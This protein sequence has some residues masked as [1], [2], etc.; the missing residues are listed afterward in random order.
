MQMQRRSAKS[1]V[2]TLARTAANA[3]SPPFLTGP[4]QAQRKSSTRGERQKGPLSRHQARTAPEEIFGS[5]CSTRLRPHK[6]LVEGCTTKCKGLAPPGLAYPAVGAISYRTHGG[7]DASYFWAVLPLAAPQTKW[8]RTPG[9]LPFSPCPRRGFSNGKMK[10]VRR[11]AI[12][13][14]L[15]CIYLEP[16]AST[17]HLNTSGVPHPFPEPKR[18]RKSETLGHTYKNKGYPIR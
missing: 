6:G 1:A 13:K 7:E 15:I 12:A 11:S 3:G 4:S 8:P 14:H 18:L 2:R 17:L 10:R 9:L 16:P 5:R